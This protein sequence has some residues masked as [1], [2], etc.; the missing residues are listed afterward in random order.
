M[1]TMIVN[2]TTPDGWSTPFDDIQI[3]NSYNPDED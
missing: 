1:A 2:P 3:E